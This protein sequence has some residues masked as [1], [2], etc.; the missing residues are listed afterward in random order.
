MHVLKERLSFPTDARHSPLSHKSN[1]KRQKKSLK[2]CKVSSKAAGGTKT[3]ESKHELEKTAAGNLC[4][5]IQDTGKSVILEASKLWELAWL[6][7]LLPGIVCSCWQKHIFFPPWRITMAV[8]LCPLSPK[9]YQSLD[10]ILPSWETLFSYLSVCF[11]NLTREPQKSQ[12]W[13]FTSPHISA[14][15]KKKRLRLLLCM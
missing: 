13:T 3:V 1:Y 6:F 14:F 8:C 7:K 12:I 4:S 9:L 2:K 10:V 11:T 15:G 5:G